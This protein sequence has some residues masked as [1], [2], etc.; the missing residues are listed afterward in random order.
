MNVTAHSVHLQ[1]DQVVRQYKYFLPIFSL[2][3]F[4]VCLNSLI[5]S[6]PKKFF[7]FQGVYTEALTVKEALV[8]PE[9]NYYVIK[10]EEDLEPGKIY[11]K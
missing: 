8:Y 1:N 10:M 3:H 7:S 2:R 4:S 5:N 11:S 6:I 9:N